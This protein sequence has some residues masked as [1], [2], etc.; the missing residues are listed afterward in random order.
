MI[1]CSNCGNEIKEG[2]KFCS[3][4]GN[5]I[6]EQ[7]EKSSDEIL[8]QEKEC[9][10]KCANCGNEIREGIKFCSKCG[11][12]VLEQQEKNDMDFLSEEEENT[13][14]KNKKI[15]YFEKVKM[16]G[17]V[18]YKIIRTEARSNGEDLEINQ[19]IHRFLRKNKEHHWET[20]L[21]EISSM[22]I[23]TKMDFWDTL[24]AVL[25]GVM[26]LLD[27]SDIL[28][29]LFIAVFLYT[30]YGKILNLRMK[31]GLNFEIPV[32]GMTEDVEKFQALLGKE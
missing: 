11:K 26:F 17:R 15:F 10:K 21:S 30:G 9:I 20:K 12:R 7:Q 14:E 2:T 27:I 19:N 23:K 31:N 6:L 13:K 8:S 4:C 5:N 32:N 29:L 16:I 24:Y 18:R 1:K 3:K 22:E 28:W 25:F